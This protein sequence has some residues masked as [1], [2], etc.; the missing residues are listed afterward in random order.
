MYL[1][2]IFLCKYICTLTFLKLKDYRIMSM[3][4]GK[5]GPSWKTQPS[6]PPPP[7]IF[8]LFKKIIQCSLITTVLFSIEKGYHLQKKKKQYFIIEKSW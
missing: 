7:K 2:C 4:D 8:Q 1:P 3:V 5:K 6:Q